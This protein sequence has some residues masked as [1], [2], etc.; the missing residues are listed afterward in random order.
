MDFRF[1]EEQE[2]IRELARS[3]LDAEAG[4][5]R[6]KEVEASDDWFDESLWKQLAEVNL[7]GIALPEEHGGMEMGFGELCILLEE[8][9]RAVAPLPALA[10]LVL[11]GLPVAGFGS[12]AQRREWLPR[13]CRGEALLS[14]ALVDAGS[15]DPSAPATRA[16][17]D[18]DG[19]VLHGDKRAVPFARVAARILVPARLANGSVA[20]FLVAP[21]ADGVSLQ[22]V[23]TSSGEPLFD[24]QLTG[25]RVAADE[26]LGGPGT[27]GARVAAW[28][29]DRALVA[30]SALQVGVSDRAIEITADYTREREQ[31]G[32][33]IGTFQ[34]VQHRM[35]D[36]FIDLQAMRWTMW[37]A[38]WSLDAGGSG[39]REARVAKYWA[40]EGGSRI[41]NA[42]IHLHGGLGSDVDYPIH[43]YFIWSKAI[44][45]S[46]GG[47]S[48]QLVRLGAD[49][50]RTGPQEAA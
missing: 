21:G 12:D 28:V 42:C 44:E 38:A 15:S 10:S 14:A 22:E 19:F 11:G 40:A 30:L 13:L 36:A 5:D 17:A 46:L 16:V 37:R 35:A 41:A 6:V 23:R 45:L 48:P 26:A 27:D 47:S 18:G 33:P 49:M 2:S 25:V 29:H 3:I 9:G 31:F 32:V 7:L 34:A 39:S 24:V 50:A 1:S 20:I 4:I 43:R 8:L